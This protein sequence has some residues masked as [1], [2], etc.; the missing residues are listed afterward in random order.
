VENDIMLLMKAILIVL[1][2]L[3][4]SLRPRGGCI[5]LQNATN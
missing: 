1:L 3:Q 2:S 4:K 5:E